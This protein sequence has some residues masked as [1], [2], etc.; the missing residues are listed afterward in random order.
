MALV[1]TFKV[2]VDGRMSAWGREIRSSGTNLSYPS[3]NLLHRDHGTIGSGLVEMSE[4]CCQTEAIMR[5]VRKEAWIEAAAL[6]AYYVYGDQAKGETSIFKTGFDR[7][8]EFFDFL[9]KTS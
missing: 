9:A 7:V 2:Y 4:L 5:E 8:T 6:E 3:T 1:D